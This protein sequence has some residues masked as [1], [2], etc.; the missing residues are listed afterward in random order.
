MAEDSQQSGQEPDLALPKLFGRRKNKRERVV[1]TTPTEDEPTRRLPPVP[2]PGATAP[3]VEPPAPEPVPAPPP[4]PDPV[5]PPA[6]PPAPEPVPTPGPQPFPD[7]TPEPQ[8]GPVRIRRE[9]KPLTLPGVNPWVAAVV[10][11]ALCGF[12]AVLLENGAQRGCQSVRGVGS[13]GGVGLVALLVIV[14]IVIALGAVLLRAFG[15]TEPTGT[16]FL[17]VGIVTVL[18]LVFFLS[19]L[20]SAWMFLVLPVLAGLCFAVSY[21]V[22]TALVDVP[23]D[24]DVSTTVR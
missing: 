7:P 22:T 20:D 10:T 9:R 24:E 8:P 11:G 17:G 15:V 18:A 21:W 1:P 12:V 13:C 3:P 2:P 5:G 14:A 4:V 19:A 23:R 6:P 16:S